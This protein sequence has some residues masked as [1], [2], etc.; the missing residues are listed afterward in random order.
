MSKGKPRQINQ[1]LG[2]KPSIG[3]VPAELFFPWLVIS[4]SIFTITQGFLKLSWVWTLILVIW[5]CGVWLILVG[6]R[7]YA[8][9]GKF[10]PVPKKWSRGY[11]R[12][13]SLDRLIERETLEA[14]KKK[15]KK[16][17]RQMNS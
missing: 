2:A 15:M 10:L 1:L 4:G 6:R 8:F 3:P 14:L 17:K 16:Q 9:L 5:G 7:P 13:I 12:Y 11:I